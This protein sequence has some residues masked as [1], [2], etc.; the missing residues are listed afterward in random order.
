MS[1]YIT[2]DGW[3]SNIRFS[4]AHIIYE[5]EKCGRIHGHTYAVHAKITGKTDDKGII[6]DFSI[7]KQILRNITNE[8]DHH[9][10]IPEKSSVSKIKKHDESIEILA[11][12]KRFLF[13]KE[14]CV[15]LP[16][17]STSAENLAKYILD[18]LLERLEISKEISSI[19]I[20]V[21]E[22]YGQGAKISKKFN[23]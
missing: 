4:C 19:E 21:D 11:L 16:I 17:K 1:S 15:F 9:L 14:D 23:K 3:R 6:I 13:P 20:G 18:E 5:Y 7:L 10:L 8:L 22:G 2:I 12:N